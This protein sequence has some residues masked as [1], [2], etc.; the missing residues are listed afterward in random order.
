MNTLKS[1]VSLLAIALAST[2]MA[3]GI[4]QTAEV[5]NKAV[6]AKSEAG[7]FTAM[8]AKKGGSG[9]DIAYR[10]DGT[11]EVGRALAISLSV[12]SSS[13]AQVTLRA[14]DGIVLN[15]PVG[16]LQSLGGQATLHQVSVTPSAQGRFYL[17]AV[18]L[19]NGRSTASSIAVQVGK[20]AVQ[21]KVSGNVQ[22]MPDGER[23]IS[24]PAR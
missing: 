7:G 18:S 24:V 6:K 15:H 12:S 23:V 10:I 20:Q 5:G 21:S 19:A 1:K 2:A 4:Q 13:D 3:S 9:V 11:P 8:P 17:H 22:V 16:P 14:G